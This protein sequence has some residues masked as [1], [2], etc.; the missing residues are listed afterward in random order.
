MA[1]PL[2]TGMHD[3]RITSPYATTITY[4]FITVTECNR[5]IM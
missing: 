2:Q 3:E 5:L 1:K 4:I